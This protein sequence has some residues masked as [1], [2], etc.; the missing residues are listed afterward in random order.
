MKG[1]VAQ[2][3]KWSLPHPGE[4][5]SVTPVSVMQTGI[6][7]WINKSINYPAIYGSVNKF[8][9]GILGRTSYISCTSISK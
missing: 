5:T 4:S 9:D 2:K 3:R 6:Y 8:L 1:K 7:Q